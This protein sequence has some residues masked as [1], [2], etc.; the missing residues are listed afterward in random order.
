[1]GFAVLLAIIFLAQLGSVFTALEVRR[2]V[3]TGFQQSE[4]SEGVTA[5][6]ALREE[7]KK[8][9]QDDA[10]TAKWDDLQKDQHCCGG[11]EGYNEFIHLEENSVPDSC[12]IESEEGCGKNQRAKNKGDLVDEI[13][14]I[15]CM[16]VLEPKLENEVVKM[17]IVY[18][19]V[20]V[21]LALVE[22]ISVVLSC[23]FVAQ[24]SRRLRKENWR[25]G[26]AGY[27]QAPNQDETDDVK[28]QVNNETVC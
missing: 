3:T 20:G 6:N 14:V 18:A 5:N 8:Y 28:N 19:A 11:L 9:G 4:N 1:M 24:I 15:G 27:V 2:Y 22:L 10:I 21:L 7:L 17:M 13:F 12:C 23:A 25:Q 26:D 16:K